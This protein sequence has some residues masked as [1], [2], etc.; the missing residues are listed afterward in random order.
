MEMESMSRSSVKDLSSST[1]S[2]GQAGL[3]VDDFSQ[4]GQDFFV[5]SH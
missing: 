5:A 4:A 1:A 3:F 2:G